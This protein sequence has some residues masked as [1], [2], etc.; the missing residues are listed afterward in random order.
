MCYVY[1]KLTEART[2]DYTSQEIDV[3]TQF[4]PFNYL[5]EQIKFGLL[6]SQHFHDCDWRT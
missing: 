2:F 4:A 1:Q 6:F 5:I 3:C